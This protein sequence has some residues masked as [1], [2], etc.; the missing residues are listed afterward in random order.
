MKNHESDSLHLKEE[1]KTLTEK[2]DSVKA[3]A[4]SREKELQILKQEKDHLQE[5]YLSECKRF[6]EI[7]KRCKDAERDSKRA[8][9]LADEVRAEA[10][11][12]QKEKSEYQRLAMERLAS[13]ERAQRQADMLEREK[14]KL[15]DEIDK[16][17]QSEADAL[18]KVNLLEKR[19][20]EREKEIEEM[21]DQNNQQRSSTVQVLEG[22]LATEREARGEANRRAEA[23][24]LQLQ[25]TQG[26]LD[27]LQQEMTAT[28]LNESALDSRLKG[29]RSK[30]DFMGTESVHDM[31]IDEEEWG[32]RKKRSKSTTSPFK[33]NNNNVTTSED[34]GSVFRGE[35]NVESP[36]EDY[37]KFTVLKL[38]QELTKHGF[39]AQLLQLKNPNKKD[40]L[41]LY[42]KHVISK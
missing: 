8:I 33:G 24:S 32:K 28:R 16:V 18:C 12:V 34:G 23:L 11:T 2:L 40:I 9:E 38:K 21:L 30:S 37:M 3:E 1:I 20:E 17:K 25:A 22:L 42:E 41:A 5:K 26:K 29:K 13:I 15:A 39:G 31:D 35:G 6:D 4:L 7:D 27:M 10:A 36:G 14:A 19:V